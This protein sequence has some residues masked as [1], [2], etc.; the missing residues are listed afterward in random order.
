[1]EEQ[2]MSD[3]RNF[4]EGLAAKVNKDRIAGMNS[5]FQFTITGDDAQTW[6][7]KIADGEVAVNEGAADA[8]NVEIIMADADFA[9]LIAGKLNSMAAF[10]SGKLKVKGDMTLSL[11]LGPIFGIS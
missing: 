11:K 6:N 9:D 10:T 4:F 5:T 7:I 1:M 2:A 8:A 3:V